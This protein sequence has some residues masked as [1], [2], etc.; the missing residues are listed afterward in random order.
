M[1][2]G[3]TKTPRME[4]FF[5]WQQS[6]FGWL[7]EGDLP[8]GGRWNFDMENREPAPGLQVTWPPPPRDPL[9]DLDREI[10]ASLLET[11][12]DSESEGTWATDRKGPL[13]RFEDFVSDAL[14]RFGPHQD[15]M[16]E[17]IWHLAHSL[18][19]PYLN[20]G[21]LSPREVCDTGGHGLEAWRGAHGE[22]RGVPGSGCWPAGVRPGRLLT[23]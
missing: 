6:R 17:R 23:D 14:A 3:Q 9:D 12:F 13:R 7:M 1:G 21:L 11:A 15:A 8:V 4:D 16:T 5:R 18:L 19:S 22:R 10:V 20:L 2:G